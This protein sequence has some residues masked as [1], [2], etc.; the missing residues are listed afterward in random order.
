MP[1]ILTLLFYGVISMDLEHSPFSVVPCATR[2][3]VAVCESDCE[4][5]SSF[6]GCVA[7]HR[8]SSSDQL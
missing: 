2:A 3:E 5:R 7:A 8:C 1:Q 4:S 6:H